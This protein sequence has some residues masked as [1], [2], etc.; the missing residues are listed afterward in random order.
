MKIVIITQEDAYYIPRLIA[1]LVT[2]RRDD[3]AA[4]TIVPGEMHARNVRKYWDFLGPLDFLRYTARYGTYRLLDV[5]LPR[6]LDGRFYSVRAVARRFRIPVV[7]TANVNAPEYL[8]RLR[9]IGVDLVVSVAAPQ[10][11]KAELLGTPRYGCINVHN[12]LLPRYQGMLPSFWVLANDERYSGTTVHYM[13]ERT[14]AGD[15]I[16]QERVEIEPEDTLHALVYRTKVTI[17]P[18]LL[19]EAISMIERGEIPQVGT[20]PSQATYHSFP[21]KRAVLKF[22]QL[23]RRFR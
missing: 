23:G 12:S 6:G 15:I 17:G 5:L 1:R 9:G 22:R 7:E 4:I 2:Q 19:L 18:R 10:I 3:L 8:E 14:D 20:D 13:N 11:F 16:V 21:D